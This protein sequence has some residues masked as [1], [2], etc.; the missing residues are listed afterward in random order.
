M[1][2]RALQRRAIAQDTLCRPAWQ[3]L[4]LGLNYLP[5][6]T[7]ADVAAAHR[8]YAARFARPAPAPFANVPDPDRRLR[9][10]MLSGDFRQ[11]PV[12]YFLEAAITAHRR[13]G[14]HLTAYDVGKRADAT[15]A[16][17]RGVFDA[18]RS[19]GALE[20]EAI[21]AQIRADA[22]DTPVDPTGHTAASRIGVMEY[23]P[24]PWPLSTTEA[25]DESTL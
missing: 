11:H 21:V 9:I 23:R 13:A 14:F 5:S 25:A 18:W 24:A 1:E 4:L 17:L 3:K 8:A 7:A 12:G 19:V 10:G 2:A 16:R 6:I 20:D 22:I 15:T